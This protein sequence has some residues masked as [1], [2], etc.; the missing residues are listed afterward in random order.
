MDCRK[1]VFSIQ[2]TVRLSVRSR[3]CILVIMMYPPET[4]AHGAAGVKAQMCHLRLSSALFHLPS[5]KRH[6]C[7]R[8]TPLRRLCAASG[9]TARRRSRLMRRS[10]T[11]CAPAPHFDSLRPE[12]RAVAHVLFLGWNITREGTGWCTSR[13]LGLPLLPRRLTRAR[14]CL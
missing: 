2:S 11:T 10:T 7:R 4:V 13:P 5:Q 8:L 1:I 12:L 9:A 3:L 14:P 6:S